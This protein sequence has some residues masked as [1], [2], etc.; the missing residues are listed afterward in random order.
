MEQNEK[1]LVSDKGLKM[2]I[3]G[4]EYGFFPGNEIS[5]NIIITNDQIKTDKI[6]L[7]LKKIYYWN[8]KNTLNENK[9]IAQQILNTENYSN[10]DYTFLIPEDIEPSFEYCSHNSFA[11][12]RYYLEAKCISNK[13]LYNCSYLILI[14]GKYINRIS[15]IKYEVK[16]DIS[17][18]FQKKGFCNVIV[19]IDKNY[20]TLDD[21]INLDIEI[22][23]ENCNLDVNLIKVNLQREILLSS[24]NK[25]QIFYERKVNNRLKKEVLIKRKTSSKENIK[26]KIDPNENLNINKWINPYE[27]SRNIINYIPS[28]DTFFIKSIYNLKITIYFDSLYIA[29]EYRPRIIIPIYYG[30]QT[31]DEYDKIQRKKNTS[32]IFNS[33]VL[34]S[35]FKSLNSNIED[36][37]NEEERII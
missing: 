32:S 17:Q 3:I 24:L 15:R 23:N 26:I 12:I 22:H 13:I 2:E 30:H 37:K 11:F 6:Y 33:D 19:Y 36:F 9:V 5:G 20:L 29:K 8:N 28:V 21:E 1:S 34:I 14:K 10:I 4:R 16:T 7:Q 31:K 25:K 18:Y 35:T 27:S